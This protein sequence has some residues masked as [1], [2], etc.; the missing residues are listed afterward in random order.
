MAIKLI[1]EPRKTYSWAE[2]KRSKPRFS[3]ALDGIV[4]AKTMRDPNGPYANFDHHK[5]VDR[6]ATR[7][8]SDQVHLEINMGLYDTFRENGIPT[9]NVYIN[10]PDEDTCLAWWL[11]KNHDRVVDH[12]EPGINRLVYCE[13]RLDTTGGGYPFGETNMRRKMAWTFEPYLIARFDGRVATMDSGEMTNVVEA[14][15][16]RLTEHVNGSGGE[17]ALEGHYERIGGGKG[18]ALTKETGPASRMAMY[19]EGVK[20][21]VAQ[22]ADKGDGSYVYTIGRNSVWTPFR[23]DKI[24]RVLNDAESDIVNDDNKWGGSDTI[25]GSPRNTGSRLTPE[26]VQDIINSSD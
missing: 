6:N 16:N 17:I 18:W 2:F 13:D 20:A 8:T 21:F 5:E 3:I 10:D 9:A 23:L 24:Y 19:N 4:S 26:Q 1:A 15:E 14:V 25:G 12:A 11:L 7:S 22:V